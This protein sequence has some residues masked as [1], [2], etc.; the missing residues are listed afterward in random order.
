MVAPGPRLRTPI[1]LLGTLA[2]A[3][4]LQ[5]GA[6]PIDDLVDHLRHGRAPVPNRGQAIAVTLSPEDLP[7]LA[8]AAAAGE[9]PS[10]LHVPSGLGDF[11]RDPLPW[12]RAHGELLRGLVNAGA[13]VVAFDLFF[14]APAPQHSEALIAAIEASRRRGVP[15]IL[16]F[17]LRELRG[18]LYDAASEVT[19]AGATVDD[20]LDGLASLRLRFR[21]PGRPPHRSL[22]LAAYAHLE[23]RP[24]DEDRLWLRATAEPFTEI[25]YSDVFL[26]SP[27]VLARR[28]GGRAV[29]I[30]VV[31]RWGDGELADVVHL[32][33]LPP[34]HPRADP[35]DPTSVHGLFVHLHAFNQ[36]VDRQLAAR[37]RLPEDHPLLFAIGLLV[38]AL[39]FLLPW[40]AYRR[41]PAPGIRRRLLRPPLPTLGPPLLL[42]LLAIGLWRSPLIYP[43][44]G[45]LAVAL[46]GAAGGSLPHWL[47]QRQRRRD[48]S[49][50]LGDGLRLLHLSD[51]HVE[52][53]TD[54]EQLLVPLLA[55]LRDPIE[56]L[57]LD[58]L[59]FL[60]VSGDLT[61]RASPP[62]LQRARELL[63]RLATR[64]GVPPAQR[65][66]VP[67]N[68][69]VDWG[70]P[71][72]TT[73]PRAAV[74]LAKLAPGTFVEQGDQVLIRDEGRYGARLRAYGELI[75][76]PLTGEP[77]PLA[78]AEQAQVKLFPAARL[79][80]L[81]LDSAWE[82]DRCF[83]GRS[84]IHLGA[85]ARGLDLAEAQLTAARPQLGDRPIVRL[86]IFHHPVTGNDK[87]VDDA[88]LEQLRRAGFSL[89]L[90]G[91]VHESRADLLGYLHPRQLHVIGAG[92]FGAPARERPESTPR[93]Y[94]LLVIDPAQRTVRVH[95]RCRRR[96]GGAWEGFSVWPGEEPNAR[97]S[98]YQVSLGDDKA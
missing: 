55:D 49:A 7:R 37:R 62:E 72:Y 80:V 77:Y 84:S 43:Q 38:A 19:A 51:L 6:W 27:E 47:A 14:E 97:R 79:Q 96:E 15:V 32:P 74:E 8:A 93:L 44:I 68:H 23:R 18:P 70:E 17:G 83:P 60:V 58:R 87:I 31:G 28:V 10:H 75:H 1:L 42:L 81:L 59:D 39:S 53:H 16:T 64:L 3:V 35:A 95:T 46:L 76:A 63:E 67:G 13:R 85:L 33:G 4:L 2:V 54:V 86:A 34:G 21:A 41:L 89:C 61:D 29:F 90:H 5:R 73:L 52:A 24:I 50:R 45:Y 48:G 56:G 57:G 94:N 26:S 12:R 36:L 11:R 92:T 88:F 20:L 91:H 65:L 66:L 40:L 82:T 98:Y 22:A 69:D 25:A 78:P 30:G 9:L 71:V